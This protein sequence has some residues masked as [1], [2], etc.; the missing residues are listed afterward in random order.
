MMWTA[1]GA[2][3]G[4]ATGGGV[5]NKRE[6]WAIKRPRTSF[7]VI[8]QRGLTSSK[9]RNPAGDRESSMRTPHTLHMVCSFLPL[10]KRHSDAATH[11]LFENPCV[12]VQVAAL[13]S[14]CSGTATGSGG[15]FDFFNVGAR[16][17]CVS[18]GTKKKT[19]SLG[20][21]RVCVG[22]GDEIQGESE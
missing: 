14:G 3:V 22:A 21:M 12:V 2:G 16:M 8:E 17:I 10:G 15:S 20:H 11:I 13:S 9:K 1:K 5:E 19:R 4:C 7:H 6:P 18:S